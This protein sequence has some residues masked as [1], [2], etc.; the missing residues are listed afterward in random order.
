MSAAI[1]LLLLNDFSGYGEKIFEHLGQAGLFAQGHQ[2]KDKAGFLKDLSEYKPDVI[3]LAA[4]ISEGT[5]DFHFEQ[6]QN[7]LVEQK[8]KTPLWMV[9]KPEDEDRAV[10]AMYEGLADYFFTDRLARLV[11]LA[12]ALVG[13]REPSSEPVALNPI[14]ERVVEGKQAVFEAKGLGLSFLP[15]VDLP[16]FRGEPALVGRAILAVLENIIVAAPPGTKSDIRSYLDAVK[17][18]VCLE[19]K[20]VGDGLQ[21]EKQIEQ[22]AVSES[23]LRPAGKIVEAQNGRID[24]D[25]GEEFGI[26]IR[27]S[28]PA[29]LKKQVTGSPRLLIV[30]NSLLMRSILQEALEQEGFTVR[31]AENGVDAL[32]KMADFRPELIISDI[33]MPKMDGFAFFEAVRKWPE[34]Q[35]I[36]FIFVTGQS[37]QKEHLDAQALRGATYLIK[38]IIIEELLVAVHSRL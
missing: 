21:T 28:F 26:R 22:T 30:E 36:P 27:V 16:S 11:P 18:E 25:G 10:A 33:M 17:G 23:T 9:V 14:V 4:G 1:C 34:G 29:I 20:L 31:A 13:Y 2:P 8:A 3:L 6:V 5:A 24:V 7:W 32:E 35:D 19:V 38:P 15:G 37:E 12:V